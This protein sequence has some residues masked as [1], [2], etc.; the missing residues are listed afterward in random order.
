MIRFLLDRHV[1]SI[2]I[3]I[4]IVIAGITCLRMLPV[5]QFPKLSP[6][7]ITI[8]ASYPGA[9]AETIALSV[10]AQLESAITGASDMIY[11]SSTSSS[12]GS[13]TLSAHFRTG[14]DVNQALEDIKSR[15]SSVNALLPDEVRKRGITVTKSSSDIVLVIALQDLQDQYD[16]MFLTNYASLRLLPEL[17]RVEGVSQVAVM[18]A[19]DYSMRIWLQPDRMAQ[20]KLDPSNIRDAILEQNAFYSVGELGQ[21]PSPPTTKLTIPVSATGLLKTVEDFENVI[22]QANSD[23]SMILLKDVSRVELGAQSYDTYATLNGKRGAFISVQKETDANALGV[24][25]GIKKKMG[26]L[27][28]FFPS[29][30]SYSIPYDTTIYISISI[31]EVVKTLIEAVI[32]VSV[33]VFIFLGSFRAALIPIIAMIVS[34]IGTFIGMYILDYSINTLSLFGLT[35]A[36]GIVVDDAIVV[37]ENVEH[38]MVVLG[39]PVKEAV[40]KTMQNV[41]A[42]IIAIVFALFSVFIPVVFMSGIAGG[43]YKQFAV[44][45]VISVVLS[46][47]VALTLSPVLSV[48]LLKNM[49]Q[50][51]LKFAQKFNALFAKLTDGYMRGVDWLIHK[52]SVGIYLC[53]LFLLGIG[54]LFYKIPPGFIPNDDQGVII[55]SGVL[56]DGASLNRTK[57]VASQVEKIVESTAGVKDSI[58]IAGGSFGSSNFLFYLSLN[59]WSQRKTFDLHAFQIVK[60]LNLQLSQ[61]PEA[62]IVAYSLPPIPGIGS[63]EFYDFWV[64]NQGTATPQD[65]KKVLDQIVAK[66]HQHREISYLN[67]SSDTGSLG[68]ELEVDKTK[69]KAFGVKLGNL[70][71]TLQMLLGSNYINDFNQYGKMYRVIA[72]AEPKFRNSVDAIG[73]MFISSSSSQGKELN[74]IPL[75][76]FVTPK[77]ASVPTSVT[78][79]NGSPAKQISVGAAASPEKAIF[80]MEQT[81]K[82]FLMPGM[83]FTWSGTAYE[84]KAA[85][86]AV[87][88]AFIGGMIVLFLSLAALYNRWILPFSVFLALPFGILGALLAVWMRGLSMD[89]YFQI[90][91]IASIG[92][93]A[94]NAIL[95][96]EF[97]RLKREEGMGVIESATEAARLRFRAIIMTSLTLILAMFPLMI[98]TGAGAAS[99]HSIGTGVVGGIF[100]ATLLAIFFVPFFFRF[101]E[102]EKP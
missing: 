33:V 36:V 61:I 91:L 31:K 70:F 81:A 84:A 85:R 40:L 45:I 86:S 32:L 72:Q 34:I 26:E 11:M 77:F 43:L 16:E 19:S 47:F 63:S 10:T 21:Q 8:S 55:L 98:A 9:S 67:T 71:Y 50:K 28:H 79:Y 83:S 5:E 22:I 75:K 92:I 25:S 46:G 97:A 37:V 20:F 102:R 58:T 74:M 73:N 59:D 56:P 100:L 65:M 23:G 52:K 57:E 12:P 93:S 99:K 17:Q 6:P 1:L 48:I 51:P 64:I 2:G 7:V 41:T 49:T 14:I 96:V 54:F 68:I 30:I 69:A 29:G 18:N 90:G 80:A 4:I 44:T 42:P 24:A 89:L 3:S 94:K 39:L 60:K 66:G 76:S 38:N 53:I 15:I 95:I 35:L 87:L 27:S 78:H 62:K 82:E 88:F 101:L 13:M